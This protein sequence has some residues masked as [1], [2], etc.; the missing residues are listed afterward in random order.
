MLP[1]VYQQQKIDTLAKP[2]PYQPEQ[3]WD[4]FS[5]PNEQKERAAWSTMTERHFFT[6][7]T[8]ELI[9]L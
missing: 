4:Q 7:E 8:F 5:G 6:I 2:N 1:A 9:I 3:H